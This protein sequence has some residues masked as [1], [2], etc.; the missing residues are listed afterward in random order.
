MD[1][2]RISCN[3]FI[4]SEVLPLSYAFNLKWHKCMF[5]LMS[6][7]K[8]Y[9]PCVSYGVYQDLIQVHC[10]PS[11]FAYTVYRVWYNFCAPEFFHVCFDT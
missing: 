7:I 8:I 6:G 9:L 1:T 11:L 4:A 5:T 2:K 3:F 10:E